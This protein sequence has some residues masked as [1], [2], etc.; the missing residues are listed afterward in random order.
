MS[1]LD[2]KTRGWAT[3]GFV[4]IGV[5]V[6]LY[7]GLFVLGFSAAFFQ[8]SSQVDVPGDAVPALIAAAVVFGLPLLGVAVLIAKVIV[9]RLNNP[10]DDYYSKNVEK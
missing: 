4:L 3:I 10:E 9:D 6:V 8:A 7:V 1:A 5:G 2:P